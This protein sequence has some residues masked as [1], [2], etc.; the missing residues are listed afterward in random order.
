MAVEAAEPGYKRGPEEL[1]TVVGIVLSTHVRNLGEGRVFTRW[2][3][4][5]THNKP[6]ITTFGFMLISCCMKPYD[7]PTA[8]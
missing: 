1:S 3:I 7:K 8:E 4:G 2:S 6:A 5:W